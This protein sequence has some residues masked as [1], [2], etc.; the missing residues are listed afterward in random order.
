MK[1]QEFL[2]KTTNYIVSG[3]SQ[4]IDL[5]YTQIDLDSYRVQYDLTKTC[6]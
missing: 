5:D 2:L 3:A 4:I 6:L 1:W